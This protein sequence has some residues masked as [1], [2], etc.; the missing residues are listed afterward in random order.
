MGLVTMLALSMGM[1]V[2]L[3]QFR[4]VPAAEWVKLASGVTDQFKF[5]NVSVR[6]SLIDRPSTMKIS[7]VTKGN[8]NSFDSSAQNVE[9]EKVAQFAVENYKGKELNRIDEVRIHRSEVH[10]RGCF[11]TTYEA[12]LTYAN[13]KRKTNQPFL[14]DR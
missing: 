10:G 14:R 1:M 5:E 7:Y 6:V 4:E 2:S 13:P 8:S 12:D 3:N 11:Q 9:M